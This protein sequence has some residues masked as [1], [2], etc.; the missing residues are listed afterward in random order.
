MKQKKN[1][2]ALAMILCCMALLT[3]CK[4]T[5]YKKASELFAAGDFEEARPVFESLG[6]YKEAQALLKECE[7]RIA[8]DKAV[9][10]QEAEDYAVAAEIFLSLGGYLDARERGKYCTEMDLAIIRFEAAGKYLRKLNEE[11]DSQITE[12]GILAHSEDMAL[13]DTLRPALENA[14]TDARTVRISVPTMPEKA[15]EIDEASEKMENADY[16]TVMAG[17]T[18]AS[19][20]LERSMKQY[21]LVNVPEEGYI[22]RCLRSVPGVMEIEA[23]TEDNDPNDKLGKA[24]GYYSAVYFTHENVDPGKVAYKGSTVVEKGTDGGGQ[25]EAYRTPEDAKKRN[26]YLAGF[27]G[28]ILSS[29][30]H[31]V[32]GTLVVR[33]SDKLKASQQRELEEA[34]INA[35]IELE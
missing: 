14:V 12:A 29:G 31:T 20:A 4:S 16:E 9:S 8:Y 1:L 24:G 3:G 27:N 26:D 33:T 35:L 22:I 7:T 23:A 15:A 25:I 5:D 34:I 21:S 32:I 28:S 2:K 17:I 30:S 6:D 19:E 10:L 11:L 18:E 13:D